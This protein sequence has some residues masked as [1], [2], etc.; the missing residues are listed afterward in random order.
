LALGI[1]K[2]DREFWQEVQSLLPEFM[3]E[4]YESC[5]GWQCGAM[6]RLIL[7]LFTEWSATKLGIEK[8]TISYHTFY[9]ELR[10]LGYDVPV[11]KSFDQNTRVR[12][13]IRRKKN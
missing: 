8:S 13:I 5:E 9:Q 4:E 11:V 1:V 2:T 7:R 12:G 6:A 10:R 3:N